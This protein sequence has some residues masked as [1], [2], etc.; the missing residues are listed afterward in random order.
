MNLD[1]LAEQTKNASAVK[2]L[3]NNKELEKTIHEL[4]KDDNISIQRRRNISNIINNLTKNT[5]NVDNRID[6]NN[7]GKSF[8]I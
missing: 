4:Y 7:N 8:K 1:T 6:Q 5:Y 3:L 2:Y